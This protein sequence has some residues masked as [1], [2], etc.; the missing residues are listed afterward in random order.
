MNSPRCAT[1]RPHRARHA[2]RARLSAVAVLM[3]LLAACGA[4]GE[5][6]PEATGATEEPSEA[7]EPAEALTIDF[8]TY[9]GEGSPLQQ[10]MDWWMDE[11]EARSGGQVAFQVHY[12]S[13]LL[14]A[15]EILAGIA[16]GRVQ[17]GFV[18]A[19]YTPGELPLTNIASVPGLSDSTEA[20]VRAQHSLIVGSEPY[21]QEWE[22]AGA[23]P[24]VSTVPGPLGIGTAAAV[25]TLDELSGLRIRSLGPIAIALES[26]G[27]TPVA[28]QAP[29]LYESLQRGVVD[30]YTVLPMGD[31]VQLGIHEVAPWIVRTPY[32]VYGHGAIAIALETYDALPADVKDVMAEV[33]EEFYDEALRILTEVETAAC[34]E[35]LASDGGVTSLPERDSQE[36][37]ELVG[38]AY[39]ESWR[40][41]ALEAGV[42]DDVVDEVLEDFLA[43]NEEYSQAGSSYSDGL[44][45]CA[46]RTTP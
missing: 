18:A 31:A 14:E 6:E 27:M 5:A 16:D 36:W 12:S 13:S 26:A 3:A 33:S 15:A 29:E 28:L 19:A 10:S 17:A 41:T 4:G 32:S 38:D 44:Q 34:D 7:E 1:T 8:A 25:E 9:L 43:A 20:R 46:E 23:R 45:A 30:G 42:A 40:T 22:R 11:V 24:M 39:V 21:M 2:G 35:L 37:A